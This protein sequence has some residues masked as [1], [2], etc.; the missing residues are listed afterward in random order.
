MKNNKQHTFGTY[1][2]LLIDEMIAENVQNLLKGHITCSSMKIVPQSNLQEFRNLLES[3]Q[4]IPT[5]YISQSPERLILAY[6]LGIDTCFL[7]N[8]T[9]DIGA[10]NNTYEVPFTKRL[11]R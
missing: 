7:N 1:N 5:L 10:F 3:I 2:F 9:N 4:N 11:T 8:G 6:N